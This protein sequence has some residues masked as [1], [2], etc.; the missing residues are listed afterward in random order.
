MEVSYTQLDQV[1]SIIFS[2]VFMRVLKLVDQKDTQFLLYIRSLFVASL[3]IHL[4]FLYIIKKKIKSTK[5]QRKIKIQKEPKMAFFKKDDDDVESDEN[6]T[7]EITYEEYDE[8]EV[9]KQIRAIVLQSVLMGFGHLKWGLCQPLCVQIFSP[10]KCLF[11]NPLYRC[12]LLG[13][14]I[15]RPYEDNKVFSNQQNAGQTQ[16]KTNNRRK[17][18]QKRRFSQAADSQT[19]KLE[20]GN[21]VENQQENKNEC[22]SSSES[23]E[24]IKEEE[25]NENKCV[26]SSESIEVIK[27][28]EKNENKCASSSESIEVI[29]EEAEVK[30]ETKHS[31]DESHSDF[32]KIANIEE[33]TQQ[34]MSTSNLSEKKPK[35]IVK[36]KKKEE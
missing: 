27:E 34:T 22:A 36:K 30:A 14:E 4:F 20:E 12:F 10:F 7:V 29:K 11:L 13:K 15:L 2:L 21:N 33:K 31:S 3:S 19:I 25:E 18:K 9:T 26:S 16:P 5:D 32:D 23:I 24:V 17:R 6:E 35:K 8:K 28:E 1:V